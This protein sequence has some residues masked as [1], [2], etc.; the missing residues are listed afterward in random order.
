MI[1]K[2]TATSTVI[3]MKN[4]FVRQDVRAFHTNKLS[5][6]EMNTGYS[7]RPKSDV[8]LSICLYSNVYYTLKTGR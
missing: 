2:Q 4:A 1:Q 3:R 8:R 5:S 7:G 6:V